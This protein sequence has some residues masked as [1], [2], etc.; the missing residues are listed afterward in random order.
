MQ[1]L[2]EWNSVPSFKVA[3]NEVRA[4]DLAHVSC[5]LVVFYGGLNSEF[6]VAGVC[7][8]IFQVSPWC[9]V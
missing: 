3:V 2:F 1:M 7:Y 6:R 8:P 5:E 4:R 9:S